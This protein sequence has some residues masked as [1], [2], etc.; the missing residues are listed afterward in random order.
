MANIRGYIAVSL[1]GYIADAKGGVAWLDAFQ[2]VDY[3][4][5][6]F[7]AEIRTVVLGRTTYDQVLGFGWPYAGRRGFVVTSR[8]LG[9]P[10]EGVEAWGRGVGAL[11]GHLRELDDGDAWIVGGAALQQAILEAGAID[12]LDLFIMPVTLGHGVP[13]FPKT[14]H[15]LGFDLVESASLPASIIRLTYRP[16]R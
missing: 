2:S 16:R 13:L 1:D 9:R 14:A 5:D 7:F 8:S 4:F 15:R 12:R 3:G 10:P 6:Q 11:I